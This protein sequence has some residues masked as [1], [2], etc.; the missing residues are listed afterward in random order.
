M[1]LLNLRI[2]KQLFAIKAIDVIEVIPLIE[3]EKVPLTDKGIS[4]LL[5]YR[6]T[7]TPVIDLCELFDNRSCDKKLNSRIIIVKQPSSKGGHQSIGLIAECV[8]NVTPYDESEI[9]DSGIHN[10]NA[11]HLGKVYKYKDQLI[12]LINTYHILP[13]S[14]SQNLT[15][16]NS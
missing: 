2:G 6:G 7:P 12:Q 11:K 15:G 1:L 10:K 8:T 13:D 16:E 4:G 5:N 14:I 3:L 9:I